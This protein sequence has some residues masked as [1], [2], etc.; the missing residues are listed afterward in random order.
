MRHGAIGLVGGL[1]TC[2]ALTAPAVAQEPERRLDPVIVTPSRLEQKMSETPAAVTV[3]TQDDVRASG[4][5]TLDDILRQVPGFSLF[6]RS[7]SLV[8]HPTTQ[9]VSLRGIGPSGTSRALVLFDGVPLNDP[10]GGWVYWNRVPLLGLEQVEVAR[11]GTVWGNYAL[12]GVIQ[13]IPQRVTGTSAAFDGSY[14][15]HDTTNLDLLLQAAPGPFR[16]SLEGNYF[17]TDGFKVVKASRRGAIDV[18]AFSEHGTAQ[19][20]VELRVSPDLSLFAGFNYYDEDRGNG[21][22][23]QVNDTRSYLYWAGVRAGALDAGEWTFTAFAQH[24]R[25]HSTFS[26]QALDRNSETL[27]LDQEVPATAAG[28][29][30]Q[31]SRRVGAHLL[32]AGADV[33]WVEGET[34]EEVFG[35]DVFLR[36]RV[37]GG[38]QLLPG[39]FVQDVYTPA[40][41][42]ELTAS[43]R[44]DYWVTYA[45]SRKDTPPP[46]GVPARQEFDDVDQLA[47]SPRLAALWHAT[48]TTDVRAAFYQ[49]FRAPTL[50][51]LYRVFRVRNDVTAANA[52]L[53]PERLTGG[54]VGV[55][56]RFG[57]FEGRVTG[58]WND[59][60]HLVANVT[61]SRNLPDCPPG[62]TCRQR[63]NLDL[64]RIRG[65]ETELEYRPSPA[66]RFLAAY[67]FTDARVVDAPQ[68]PNLE[69]N[70]LA[71]VPEHTYTLNARFIKPEWVNVS[72]T[73]R[74][75]GRAFED[76]ASTLSLGSAFLVDVMLSRPVAKW[77][78]VYLG[79]E[80]LVDTVYSTGRTSE[81]VVSTGT[82]RLVRGGLRLTF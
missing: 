45:A 27:A 54:E 49:T 17:D 66:W 59:V 72:V 64:A 14:G 31:W 42:W 28:G 82:P 53:R 7:S 2:L 21:T 32:T 48:P 38:Q 41:A 20:R 4:V 35:N 16:L 76:D 6:R 80:N 26:A 71:Q 15:S 23:L 52:K 79:V 47:V 78:E 62:T 77:G 25:F 39:V 30:L 50:N 29:A 11:G 13:L 33:R 19:A 9:G 12:G 44:A 55:Q 5:Q 51:E 75:V 46:A 56:Q 36:T 57:P 58:F 74:F 73:G 24:Q 10:F 37:A 22:P 8:T 61:L 65:F 67:L 60:E 63:Q 69:G 3:V 1:L 81:G 68:Q 70:R 18:D 34:D 40:P 43:V